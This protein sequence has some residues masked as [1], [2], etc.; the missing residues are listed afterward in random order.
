MKFLSLLTLAD[1]SGSS[2]LSNEFT[3]TRPSNILTRIRA[4]GLQ[5]AAAGVNRV[6][7]DAT[8]TAAPK[9]RAPPTRNASQPPGIWNTM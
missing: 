7:N 4:A 1:N 6:S 9:R 8:R 2:V 5:R 3:S